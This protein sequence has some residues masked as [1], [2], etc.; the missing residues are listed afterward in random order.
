MLTTRVA[1]YPEEYSEESLTWTQVSKKIVSAL[2]DS[3]FEK[4]GPREALET[5]PPKQISYDRSIREILNTGM[6][7]GNGYKLISEFSKTF[8]EMNLSLCALSKTRLGPK[9]M[10]SM[11]KLGLESSREKILLVDDLHG[12]D[13]PEELSMTICSDWET[14]FGDRFQQKTSIY[15]NSEG[16]EFVY[17]YSDVLYGTRPHIDHKLYELALDPN[18]PE[19]KQ[20]FRLTEADLESGLLSFSAW[21]HKLHIPWLAKTLFYLGETAFPSSLITMD[22]KLAF[23]GL[24]EEKLPLPHLEILNLSQVTLIQTNHLSREKTYR[25][26]NSLAPQVVRMGW[27]FDAEDFES[28]EII[29]RTITTAMIKIH[30]YLQD[31][32]INRNEFGQ[33]FYFDGVLHSANQLE[34]RFAENNLQGCYNRWMPLPHVFEA[35][36]VT[37]ENVKL[38]GDPESE[39]GKQKLI[40]IVDEGVGS[41]AVSSCINTSIFYHFIPNKYDPEFYAITAYRYNFPDESTNALSN[42]GISRFV[43]GRYDEA[44]K[45][46]EMALSREDKYAES[47]AAFYLHKILEMQGDKAGSEEYRIRCEKAGGYEATY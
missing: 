2:A 9:L 24:N 17:W 15:R 11:E 33:P 34:S 13:V 22:R 45:L 25:G 4:Y 12:V 40:W 28:H 8:N 42:F 27:L 20:E 39:E 10:S 1:K 26:L 31:G 16:K 19:N 3:W 35:I 46:F 30:S 36:A 32:Y 41:G 38:I 37:E 43:E 21:S 14:Y 7:V 18:E 5:L 6:V 29:L 44:K 23:S 47:E